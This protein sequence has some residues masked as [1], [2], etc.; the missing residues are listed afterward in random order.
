M[1]GKTFE[2]TITNLLTSFLDPARQDTEKV[3]IMFIQAR[4][5]EVAYGAYQWY[6]VDTSHLNELQAMMPTKEDAEE[7]IRNPPEPSQRLERESR[8]RARH[9]E[10]IMAMMEIINNKEKK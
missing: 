7:A 4:P 6:R 3:W 2:E 1:G 10:E 9:A 5:S 8:E